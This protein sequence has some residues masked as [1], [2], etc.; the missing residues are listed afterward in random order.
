VQGQVQPL[1]GVWSCRG[2]LKRHHYGILPTAPLGAAHKA[3]KDFEGSHEA[4]RDSKGFHEAFKD[5]EGSHEAS[6]DPKGFHEAF[7]EGGLKG[8][9][10]EQ[11]E[12]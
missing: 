7:K 11:S 12:G 3:L 2:A 6:R 8:F 4:S 1:W 5:F 10:Y 9:V